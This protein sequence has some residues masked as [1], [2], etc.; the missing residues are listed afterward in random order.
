M[1]VVGKTEISFTICRERD[2]FTSV[3]RKDTNFSSFVALEHKFGLVYTLLHRTFTILSDFS[4]FPFEVETLKKTLNKIAYPTKFIDKCMAK[5]LNNIFVQK[6]VFT[7]VPKLGLRIVLPY[8][9][10]ISS[11][12]KKRLN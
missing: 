12:T 11:M 1:C 6:P 7:N 9:G 4:K 5:F 2:K 8:F 10:N 3:F